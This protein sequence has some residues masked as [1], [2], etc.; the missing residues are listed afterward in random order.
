M[1]KIAFLALAL[2]FTLG[3]FAQ[4][5]EEVTIEGTYRP[6]VNKVD[7]IL[8]KPETPEQVFTMPEAKVAVLDIEHSFRITPD[9][10]S[11]LNYKAGKGFGEN[12]AKNFVLAGFGSRISPVFLFRHNS[13][14]TKNLGLGVGLKHYSSWLDLSEY[15]PSSFMNNA[16]EIGLTSSGLSGMK[17]GFNVYYKNDTYHYYGIKIADW[18]GDHTSF[19]HASPG[20]LYNTIGAHLGLTSTNTRLGEYTHDL[21]LD[22]HYLFGRVGNGSEHY[23]N[24]GYDLGFANGWWGKKSSSQKLGVAFGAQYGYDEFMEQKG[25]SRLL[26]KLNPYFEMK[27]DFYRLR[28]GAKVDAAS[29]FKTTEGLVK[30]YP[31]VKG[32]LFVLNKALEF[33]AGLDGGRKLYTYG[34][35]LEENPFLAT[36]LNFEITHVKL[37]FEGGIRTNIMNTL[38][39]HVGVRYRHTDNDLFYRQRI[40]PAYNG[41]TTDRPYNSFDLVYD[42]TRQV[43]VLGNIRWLV[44]DRMTVD[45]GFTYNDCDPE[46]EEHAWY[47]PVTEGNLKLNFQLT[48]ALSLNAN[49][50][51]Q[52]GRWGQRAAHS[53]IAAQSVKLKDVYDLGLGA[54]YLISERF[55]VFV[56]ADNLLHRK[57][58][59]YLDYPV[60]G[61]EAFVGLKM[62]F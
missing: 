62:A 36:N 8:L 12:N 59:L 6:K 27:D 26:V 21:G 11:P 52:G 45:A 25:T 54:D 29:N 44:M 49:F 23:A 38:D 17:L 16:V 58:Q 10:L 42:E 4:H 24:L 15:A 34:D 47:R 53:G 41:M 35:L 33:Y 20:Q 61:I 39:V 55:S 57:Y 46:H 5:N 56:K 9:K 3:L 7:K 22:Y 43:S 37:G 51:Y 2:S 60:T 14:L 30:V 18:T 32:S 50:L 48:D 19:E 1:K 13:N 40:T 28:L 31:D